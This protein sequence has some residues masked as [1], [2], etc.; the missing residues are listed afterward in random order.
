[1]NLSVG[2]SN[3][4]MVAVTAA[5]AAIGGME[6][7]AEGH[8][9]TAGD[10]RVVAEPAVLDVSLTQVQATTKMLVVSASTTASTSFR[11]LSLIETSRVA[12]ANDGGD[13]VAYPHLRDTA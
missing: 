1:M 11:Y 7:G 3:A 6:G 8:Q 9:G 4:T 13:T 10:G 2:A 12:A 5:A